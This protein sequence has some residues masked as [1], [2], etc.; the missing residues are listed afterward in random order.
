MA[1][2]KK[3]IIFIPFL[4]AIS[5]ALCLCTPLLAEDITTAP[6]K[7][8]RLWNLNNVDIQAVIEEISRE[9][10]KNF[11]VDPRVS[12]R[13]NIVSNK[14]MS[15]AEIYPVFLSMLQVLG[16]SAV[17]VGDIVKILP[18]NDA[19]RSSTPVSDLIQ[20]PKGSDALVVQVIPIK[21]SS[22]SKLVP[23]LRPLLPESSNLGA[24]DPAGVLII[25]ATANNVDRILK[26]VHDVDKANTNDIEVITLEQATAAQVVNVI[27]SLQTTPGEPGAGNATLA[28]DDHTNSILISGD[29]QKRMRLR[30]LIAQ[31]DVASP[32]GTTG[33][34]QVVYLHYLKAKD[35]AAILSKIAQGGGEEGSKEKP[36]PQNKV[37]IQAEP[38]TNA[39]IITA[40]P[41]MM[42]NL[43]SVVA[44]LDNRPAQV[45]VEAAIVEVDENASLQLGILWGQLAFEGPVSPTVDTGLP[46]GFNPGIGVIKNGNLREIIN[47]LATNG[48]TNILSTP[49]VLVMDNQEAKI[50]VGQNLSLETG[51]YSNTNGTNSSVSPFNTVQRDRIGLHLYVTPQINRG[52]AVQLTIDQGNETLENPNDITLTPV[53]N[54]TALKTTVLVNNG[55]ILV[56]GGLISN[57]LTKSTTKIP[58]V[59]DIPFIGA[60]FTYDTSTMTKKN[61]MIFLK[62]AILHQGKDNLAVT[63][64]KYNFIR[65]QQLRLEE[66]RKTLTNDPNTRVLPVWFEQP[67]LPSPFPNQ[68]P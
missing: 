49:S 38:T 64:S 25:S 2:Q 43:K 20:R 47:L 3:R 67:A 54:V 32:A 59:G 46:F 13:V 1:E 7:E 19:Q 14:P 17:Q 61:L 45:L 51:S 16:F 30:A 53:T 23:I 6:A 58:L 57:S 35:F 28:A 40:P 39:L 31:L 4:A 56:L 18:M 15:P 48:S 41:S 42:M 37:S 65:S 8:T 22:A 11:I 21:N 9:T 26:I 27:S 52:D 44:R 12:G 60:F 10:G 34:T 63:D 62:P 24:Y 33:N 29:A 50:E 68:L 55:D 36:G 5:L 66:P